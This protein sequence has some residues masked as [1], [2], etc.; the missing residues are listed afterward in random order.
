[1]AEATA[2][3]KASPQPL[4][5]MNVRMS[6]VIETKPM[7]M[8]N[9]VKGVVAGGDDSAIRKDIHSNPIQR[10]IAEGSSGGEEGEED[11]KAVVG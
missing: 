4:A 1:M 2:V 6:A 11:G 5:M 10:P 7:A 9:W 8:A 3:T